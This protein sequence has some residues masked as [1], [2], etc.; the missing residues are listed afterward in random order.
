MADDKITYDDFLK[1]VAFLED[2]KVDDTHFLMVMDPRATYMCLG[3]LEDIE[4]DWHSPF[5]RIKL[6]FQG[7]RQKDIDDIKDVLGRFYGRE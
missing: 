3:M 2:M 1:A 7:W 6:W 5:G 4:Y